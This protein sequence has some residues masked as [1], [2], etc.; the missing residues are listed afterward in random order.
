MK[1]R[2]TA[3]KYVKKYYGSHQ[4]S[5]RIHYILKK[6]GFIKYDNNVYN[7]EIIYYKDGDIGIRIWDNNMERIEY[8]ENITEKP[9][10][11]REI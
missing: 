10:T 6:Q 4:S 11:R 9:I 8:E 2:K 5:R 3:N 1:A 7:L